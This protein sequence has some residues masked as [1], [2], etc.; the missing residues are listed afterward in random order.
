MAE[1]EVFEDFEDEEVEEEEEEEEDFPEAPVETGRELRGGER[2][3]KP[4]ATR[5]EK[6]AL[7]VERAKMLEDGFPP[8]IDVNIPG[9]ELTDTIEIARKELALKLTPLRVRRDFPNG[10]YEYWDVRELVFPK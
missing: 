9:R 5:F 10:D 6:S 4:V 1:E 3:G 2:R 8:V 7:L